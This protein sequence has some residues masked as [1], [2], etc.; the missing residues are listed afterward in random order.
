MV[1]MNEN[2]CRFCRRHGRHHLIIPQNM[3]VQYEDECEF[4]LGHS[5]AIMSLCIYIKY[6][7]QRKSKSG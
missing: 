5:D 7:Y 2:D 6:N 4:Q 3:L 1:R